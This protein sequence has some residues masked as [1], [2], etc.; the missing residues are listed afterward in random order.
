MKKTLSIALI[1][2]LFASCSSE[3]DKPDTS[4]HKCIITDTY[5]HIPVIR[6]IDTMYTVGD[7]IYDQSNKWWYVVTKTSGTPQ[8]RDYQ[9]EVENDTTYMYDGERL[10]TKFPYS[11]TDV[12]SLAI[13]HD[14]D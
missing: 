1:A 10:V 11:D 4:L 6:Y 13:N 9:L 7:T 2:I 8:L 12:I 3:Q 14:N 5:Y